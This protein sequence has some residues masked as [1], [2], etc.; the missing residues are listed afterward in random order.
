MEGYFIALTLIITIAGFIVNGIN[1]VDITTLELRYHLSSTQ[2][3]LISSM[4]DISAGIF[5]IPVSYFGSRA[6]QPRLLYIAAFVMA[7]GSFIMCVPHWAV[8]PY[9]EI[10]HRDDICVKELAIAG[11]WHA[12][13]V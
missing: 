9:D 3:G 11:E 13:N 6:H 1:H 10:S 7:L 8:P 5:V 4:Y 2:A 12:V